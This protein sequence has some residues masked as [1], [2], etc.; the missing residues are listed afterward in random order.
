MLE[1]YSPKKAK[2]I[3]ASSEGQIQELCQSFGLPSPCLKAILYQ[4]LIQIDVLDLVADGFVRFYWWR[5]HL[6]KRLRFRRPEPLLKIGP[7]GK[8]DSSTGYAQIFTY[9]ALNA[10]N[11]A[12]DRGLAS[13]QALGIH[14]DH[15]LS[16]DEPE[17]LSMIWHTLVRDKRMNLALAALNLICAGEELNGHTD[18]EH[19]TPDEFKHMFTRYN[20]NVKQITRYGEKAYQNFL[21]YGG[22]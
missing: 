14:A 10:A 4:E 5:Y 2:Q 8:R 13:Y 9:V 17:D 6:R 20:A 15:T 19:Y 1:L 12:A 18:F 22:I 16:R 21:R 7:F 3:I 11:Y